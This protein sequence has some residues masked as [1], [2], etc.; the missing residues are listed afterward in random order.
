MLVE[1]VHRGQNSA[2]AGVEMK[3]EDV[4][5]IF[6]VVLETFLG[7]FCSFPI[8]MCDI[9]VMLQISKLPLTSAKNISNVFPSDVIYIRPQ[10]QL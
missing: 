8:F 10:Y 9:F 5:F 4:R 1:R 6:L 3:D 7:I 2:D